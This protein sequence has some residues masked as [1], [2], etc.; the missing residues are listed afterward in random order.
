MIAAIK[1]A[2]YNELTEDDCLV[3]IATD[4]MQLYELRLTELASERDEYSKIDAWMD[5]QLLDY[6][7]QG[8]QGRNAFP[9][10]SPELTIIG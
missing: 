1:Y 2:K 8:N 3:S 5:I 10:V 6:I 7:V 9:P 4:P